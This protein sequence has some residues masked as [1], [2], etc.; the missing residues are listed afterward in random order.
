MS[1]ATS[2]PLVPLHAN[3][4][5]Q[6]PSKPRNGSV[7]ESR[8]PVAHKRWAVTSLLLSAQIRL[9]CWHSVWT[10]QPPHR[11]IRPAKVGER[12]VGNCR[13]SQR[14][15]PPRDPDGG[16]NPPA[17]PRQGSAAPPPLLPVSK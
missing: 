15:N 16:Q 17:S 14:R 9:P 2:E 4:P 13:G 1:A 3:Q 7:L 5:A 8:S 6:S 12:I 10:N 11:R